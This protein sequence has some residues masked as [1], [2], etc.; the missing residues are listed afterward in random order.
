MSLFDAMGA[1]AKLS[2]TSAAIWAKALAT[3]APGS[4]MTIVA[5]QAEEALG[6]QH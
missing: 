5:K 4:D 1:D 2:R 3:A 6:L